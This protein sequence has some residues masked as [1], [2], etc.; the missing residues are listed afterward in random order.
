MIDHQWSGF[1]TALQNT[2][3]WAT[4][5]TPTDQDEQDWRREL[6]GRYDV[7][8]LDKARRMHSQQHNRYRQPDLGKF[9]VALKSIAGDQYKDHK[10]MTTVYWLCHALDDDGW[11]KI[12]ML[13]ELDYSIDEH[14]ADQQ[15]EQAARYLAGVY[16]GR[17]MGMQLP[18]GEVRRKAHEIKHEAGLCVKGYCRLCDPTLAEK[19]E[20][21]DTWAKLTKMLASIEIKV[22]TSPVRATEH[23]RLDQEKDLAVAVVEEEQQKQEP[24]TVDNG[25]DDN[26]SF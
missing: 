25:A 24:V 22:A 18:L 5:W 7:F 3:K 21:V 26:Y 12:G 11:G 16:G 23:F 6:E 14:N 17:W 20:S 2:G 4:S 15:A 10:Q 9:L 1:W 19:V 8:L 13:I